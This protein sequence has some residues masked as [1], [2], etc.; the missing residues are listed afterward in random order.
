MISAINKLVSIFLF[1]DANTLLGNKFS[2]RNVFQNLPQLPDQEKRAVLEFSL[3]N[4]KE[5][6][7]GY[8]LPSITVLI[9]NIFHLV[10]LLSVSIFIKKIIQDWEADLAE[11]E[12]RLALC[13]LAVSL[14]LLPILSQQI[15]NKVFRLYRLIYSKISYAI[16]EHFFSL[17]E[18]TRNSQVS[19]A[20]ALTSY[21]L[22]DADKVA[23]A[24]IHLNILVTVPFQL[25]CLSVL[26]VVDITQGGMFYFG[27]VLFVLWICYIISNKLKDLRIAVKK[28]TDNR[29][30]ASN[31]FFSNLQ[32]IRMSGLS[33][34]YK[35]AVENLQKIEN[36]LLVKFYIWDIFWHGNALILNVLPLLI[37]VALKQFWNPAIHLID[38]IPL[39]VFFNIIRP[40]LLLCVKT[41]KEFKQ[42]LASLSRLKTYFSQ[43]SNHTKFQGPK[44]TELPFP[45]RINC[46]NHRLELYPGNIVW[47]VGRTGAGKSTFLKALTGVVAFPSIQR[48]SSQSTVYLEQETWFMRAT[49]LDN[50][51]LGRKFDPID[52]RRVVEVCCL[53]QDLSNFENKELTE[54]G[55][56][57]IE[58]SG[59]QKQKI[60]LARLFYGLNAHL[61]LLDDPF[62]SLDSKTKTKIFQRLK[63]DYFKHCVTFI[64]TQDLSLIGDQDQVLWVDNHHMIELGTFEMM[65][66]KLELWLNES[67]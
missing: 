26:S 67:E 19:S 55:S 64:S 61:I 59:G 57:G 66:Q 39:L 58:L 41:V 52:F 35:A 32:S 6:C 30:N 25:I 48:L 43:H 22:E 14:L 56:S 13:G 46:C 42:S 37:L 28:A 54:V 20:G 65:R 23:E 9:L 8:L 62:S 7:R 51:I 2:A 45:V 33:Q 49:I 18:D 27:S 12:L 63:D 38:V 44:H 60:C 4:T 24:I 5:A 11:S 47:L 10:L 21:I 53:S 1:N 31:Y 34:S 3:V 40:S 50:I 16:I 17:S 36:R 15:L 29:I